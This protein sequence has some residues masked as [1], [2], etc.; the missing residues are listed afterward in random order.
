MDLYSGFS[1]WIAKGAIDSHFNP[2]KQDISTSVAIIG[3]GITGTLIMHEL[4]NAGIECV[5]IDEKSIAIGNI[6][7]NTGVLQYETDTPLYKLSR[8][9]G[10]KKA[11]TVY[12]SCLQAIDDLEEVYASIDYNPDLERVPGLCYSNNMEGI[13]LLRNEFEIRKKHRLPV[14]LLK[15]K[16]IITKYNIKAMNALEDP[17]SAQM[18]SYKGAIGLI[19]HHIHKHKLRV[20]TYTKITQ[21]I[22]GF[23]AYTLITENGNSV[24]C[25]YVIIAGGLDVKQFLPK[26]AI[27][28]NTSYTIISQPLDEKYVW[29][30]R[31]ILHVNCT[32]PLFIRTLNNNRIIVEGES[33]ELADPEKQCKVLKKKITILEKKFNKLFPDTPFITEFAWSGTF[34]YTSDG[35]PYI[36]AAPGSD[37]ILLFSGYGSNDIPF[38]MIAAQLFRNKIQGKRDERE[39]IFS[40]GRI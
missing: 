3:T 24:K 12:K 26:N 19:D 28:H 35:L 33:R 8:I 40:P 4:C 22:K 17:V 9:H 11:S 34:N 21:F 14:K 27:R 36:G 16:E 29:E 38:S 6:A 5:M 15:R 20:Y 23:N 30:G 10:E 25:D 37:R 2:L 32:P 39:E 18:N 31:G 13:E 1:Y 7:A